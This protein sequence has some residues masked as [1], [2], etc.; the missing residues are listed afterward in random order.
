M[1]GRVFIGMYVEIC[2]LY[3]V[4]FGVYKDLLVERWRHFPSCEWSV[5]VMVKIFIIVSKAYCILKH[6]MRVCSREWTSL[7]RI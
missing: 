4:I 2:L 7:S 3:E 1:N 6:P 5:H